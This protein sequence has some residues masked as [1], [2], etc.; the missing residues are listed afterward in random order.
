MVAPIHELMTAH[1]KTLADYPPVQG[2]KS[3][4]VSNVVEQFLSHGHD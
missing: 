3:F 2:G 1:L 4:D